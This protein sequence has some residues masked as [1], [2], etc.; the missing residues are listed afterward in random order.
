MPYHLVL[1]GE[2]KVRKKLV[3]LNQMVHSK[4]PFLLTVVAE[5]VGNLANEGN[6]S[7]KIDLALLIEDE[8]NDP[9]EFNQ[10]R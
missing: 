5:E 10:D 8:T 1:L 4:A 9:P 3:P 6:T 7:T 2:L